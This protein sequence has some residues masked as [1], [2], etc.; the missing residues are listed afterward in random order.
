M[1]VD[2]G[3]WKYTYGFGLMAD[4]RKLEDVFWEEVLE[5]E[6]FEQ[7]EFIAVRMKEKEC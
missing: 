1:E 3:L 5:D 2:A 7:Y 6:W 4:V